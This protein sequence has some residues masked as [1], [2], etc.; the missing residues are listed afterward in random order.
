M[1]KK[2]KYF[3][4]IVL[5]PITLL[6]CIIKLTHKQIE[7]KKIKKYLRSVDISK[8]DNLDG[9]GMEEFLY[10]FFKSLGLDVERTK[11]SRDYGADLIINYK[12]RKIVVQCKLYYKHSVGNS[13]IQEIA[14]AKSYYLADKGVVIT[15]SFFTKSAV[16][17]SMTSDVSLID[18]DKL[19]ELLTSPDNEKKY[20]LYNYFA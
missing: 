12:C 6:F 3:F 19:N 10:L 20:L 8:L 16:N 18:R 17:L 11:K 4:G 7:K 1:G 5:F 13:A 14:T 15:N 9:H 2:I